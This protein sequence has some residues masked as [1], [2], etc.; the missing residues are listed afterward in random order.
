MV[1]PYSKNQEKEEN[2]HVV[3]TLEIYIIAPKIFSNYTL[4]PETIHILTRILE[5][6]I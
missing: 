2:A 4:T 1:L 5:N 3:Q 6:D